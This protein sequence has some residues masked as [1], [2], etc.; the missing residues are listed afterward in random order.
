M[1]IYNL[2]SQGDTPMK[3][4]TFDDINKLNISPLQCYN[5]VDEMIYNK[6]DTQ[7]PPK[8]SLHPSDDS[9]CNIMPCVISKEYGGVKLVTRYPDRLPS[10]DSKLFLID[11]ISGNYL[12]LMDANWITA[13]RTGAVAVHSI[14]HLAKSSFKT[15]SIL[16]LGNTAR[17]TLLI[18]ASLYPNNHFEIKLLKYKE[19]EN[20]FKDRFS[21]YQNLHFTY[22]DSIKDLIKGSDII[23][24]CATYLKDDICTDDCFDKGV[25]VI[26][27]HTRGFTNCDLFFDKVFADDTSHV[28]HFKNFNKFKYFAEMCDVVQG[29]AKSRENDEERILAYNIGIAIHDINFASH[30][31]K[32]IKSVPNLF[33]SLP[34]ITMNEPKEKFWL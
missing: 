21:D 10:L 13:M 25:L 34:D 9:F 26:P 11:M 20:L 2:T 7:L 15:I 12:A 31:Y 3:L 19:Q 17:A 30:I 27:I 18:L 6:K 8:I 14:K 22:I 32:H 16:G 28:S 24:S 4:I 1:D 29:L 5:W 33:N 23:I